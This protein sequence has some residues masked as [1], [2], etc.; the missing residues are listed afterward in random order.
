[1]E[2]V[3]ES[4]LCEL[5]DKVIQSLQTSKIFSDFTAPYCPLFLSLTNTLTPPYQSVSQCQ[6][7]GFL[8]RWVPP[9]RRRRWRVHSSVQLRG[10]CVCVCVCLCMLGCAVSFC[11][12]ILIEILNFKEGKMA[13]K[14]YSKKYGVSL[15]RFTHHEVC[16]LPISLSSLSLSPFT[17]V[18]SPSHLDDTIPPH[19]KLSFVRRTTLGTSH[20]YARSLFAISLFPFEKPPSLSR[21]I[22]TLSLPWNIFSFSLSLCLLL[23]RQSHLLP[24]SVYFP[25]T[26]IATFAISK[27]SFYFPL[28]LSLHSSLPYPFQG[29]RDRVLSLAMSPSDDTFFSS[30]L[31]NTIRFWDTR[32]PNC[33]GFSL[34]LFC[35]LSRPFLCLLS[36]LKPFSLSKVWSGRGGGRWSP[37]TPQA[38][39]LRRHLAIALLNSSVSRA[40]PTAPSSISAWWGDACLGWLCV[41]VR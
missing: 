6:F 36:N 13:K 41:C 22:R 9:S 3:D 37:T 12:R 14:I 39:R 33:Q 18:H 23:Q 10:V 21:H 5:S 31:D 24:H 28:F 19:R 1:M 4:R 26:T 40:S 7:D 2:D 16:T 30:S 20:W 32:S 27:V 17:H 25:S 15:I 8:S 34:F 11:N 29:H 38:W 35:T